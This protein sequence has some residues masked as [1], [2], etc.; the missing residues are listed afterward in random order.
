MTLAKHDSAH[1]P[2]RPIS[3]RREHIDGLFLLFLVPILALAC[4]GGRD[5]GHSQIEAAQLETESDCA[6]ATEQSEV[7]D[8]LNGYDPTDVEPPPPMPSY[9]GTIA[10]K[11][12][13]NNTGAAV[14][15]I[16]I[17]V[18]PG[19]ADM[20]PDLKLSYDSSS[21]SNGIF[22]LGWSI[23]GLSSIARVPSTLRHDGVI[24]P[25]DYDALDRLSLDG[26]RL[27]VVERGYW[28]SYNEYR[29]EIDRLTYVR[30]IN[31]HFVARTKDGLIRRYGFAPSSRS[32]GC[33]K[34]TAIWLMDR[35]EDTV[36][37]FMTFEY[38]GTH[39]SVRRIKYSG[40]IGTGQAPDSEVEFVYEARP[41][42]QVHWRAGMKVEIDKRIKKIIV[43][44]QDEVVRIYAIEY[45]LSPST[46]ESQMV[47]IQEIVPG[48]EYGAKLYAYPK[49]TFSWR[50]NSATAPTGSSVQLASKLGAGQK[51]P[52]RV[53]VQGDFD[54][55]GR[56]DFIV[57]SAEN[58]RNGRTWDTVATKYLSSDDYVGKL[59]PF[60]VE[61]EGAKPCAKRVLASGDFDGDTLGDFVLGCVP[62]E[63][64]SFNKDAPIPT[65]TEVYHANTDGTFDRTPLPFSASLCGKIRGSGDFNGDGSTDILLTSCILFSNPS[66]GRKAPFTMVRRKYLEQRFRRGPEAIDQVQNKY[67]L[68]LLNFFVAEINGDGVADLVFEY[69]QDINL[70]DGWDS[71]NYKVRV[72][73]HV[74]DGTGGFSEAFDSRGFPKGARI[75]TAG[76]FNGDGLTDFYL[77]RQST[78]DPRKFFARNH[79]V[80]GKGQLMLADGLGGFTRVDTNVEENIVS[81]EA[82]APVVIGSGDFNGDGRTD[83]VFSD[84]KLNLDD[85]PAPTV[86]Q[87]QAKIYLAAGAY[88]FK[89]VE[90]NTLG[91]TH[92]VQAFGDF[93]GDGRSQILS[94]RGNHF[95][96]F[97]LSL[98]RASGIGETEVDRITQFTNGLGRLSKLRYRRPTVPATDDDPEVYS[99]GEGAVFPIVDIHPS[100]PVVAQLW[101]DTGL[102]D[103]ASRSMIYTY[104]NAR[105]D[106]LGRGFLGFG[107][108]ESYD[109]AQNLST[110]EL[111]SQEFPHI[112][113][114]RETRTCLHEDPE[115]V[116]TLLT[117][118]VNELAH[119]ST[120]KSDSGYW[121]EWINSDTPGGTGDHETIFHTTVTAPVPAVINCLSREMIECKS[122]SGLTAAETG[123][124]VTC[125]PKEGFLCLNSE[126]PDGRCDHDYEVRYFCGPRAISTFPYIASAEE[127]KWEPS[128][129][130]GCDVSGGGLAHETVKT[131]NDFDEYGNNIRIKTVWD[132]G[133][134]TE[135]SDEVV[136]DYTWPENRSYFQK[137]GRVRQIV[138][139]SKTADGRA[140]S[141]T[142]DFD[143]YLNMLLRTQKAI[144][145]PSSTTH[146]EYDAFGNRT[147]TRKSGEGA[148]T[149]FEQSV[150]DERGRFER[151][152]QNALGHLE[153]HEYDPRF[154]TVTRRVG[155][156]TMAALGWDT[157]GSGCP[158]P[159]EIGPEVVSYRASYDGFG[160][161]TQSV[162]IDGK[163]TTTRIVPFVPTGGDDAVAQGR[164]RIQH[165]TLGEI[166]IEVYDRLGRVLRAGTY[167]PFSVRSAVTNTTYNH[168]GQVVAKSDRYDNN[169]PDKKITWTLMDYDAIGRVT[170]TSY[171]NGL[172]VAT[173][174]DGRVTTIRRWPSENPNNVRQSMT[175]TDARSQVTQ[176]FD[177]MGNGVQ[178]QYGPFGQLETTRPSVG[179]KTDEAYE[180]KAL[181]DAQGNRTALYDP[182]LGD[183]SYVYNGLGQMV[184]QVD[185]NGKIVTLEYDAIG[186]LT[187]QETPEGESRWFFD[188]IDAQNLSSSY[189]GKLVY[190]EY[191]DDTDA[192]A[193][194]YGTLYRYDAV[195]HNTE[196]VRPWSELSTRK[197]LEY[198]SVGRLTKEEYHATFDDDERHLLSLNYS[199]TSGNDIARIEDHEGHLWYDAA[200]TEG[201]DAT[202]AFT[203]LG[204]DAEG[205]PTRYRV[206]Q[207]KDQSAVL[208]VEKQYNQEFTTHIEGRTNKGVLRSTR[209]EYDALG[210]LTGRHRL[211]PSVRNEWFAYDSLNRLT[212]TE[213]LKNSPVPTVM[214]DAHGNITHKAT[215]GD[216]VYGQKDTNGRI[217]FLHAVTSAGGVSY[218]YDD[219]G[220]MLERGDTQILWTAFNKPWWIGGP[221]GHAR[222]AYDANR[223]RVRQES[224]VRQ[225]LSRKNGSERWSFER[226]TKL[227]ID[228]GLEVHL[229]TESGVCQL[230]DNKRYCSVDDKLGDSLAKFY[231]HGPD[232]RLGVFERAMESGAAVR[233][234]FLKDHLGSVTEV[235]GPEGQVIEEM[236]YDAWGERRGTTV[237]EN[238]ESEALGAPAKNWTIYDNSPA[239]AQATVVYDEDKN[240]QVV[241]LS[242]A[243]RANGASLNGPDGGSLA[244]RDRHILRWR[245]KFSEAFGF[246]VRVMTSAGSRFLY[247]SGA[248][249][250][251]EVEVSELYAHHGLGESSMDG[252]WRTYTR[253]LR[254]DLK[255]RFPELEIIELSH[256]LIR[257]SGRI[258]DIEVLVS[259]DRGFTDH[260]MLDLFGL[261]HMNG[262]IYDPRVG[263][264]LSPD[265]FV[266][267]ELDLQNHNR[268]SYVLNRPLSVTDP[269]GY[270]FSAIFSAVIAIAEAVAAIAPIVSVALP[271]LQFA[272]AYAQSGD[273]GLAF[274]VL[275]KG[276]ALSLL[277]VGVTSGIGAYFDG[278]QASGLTVEL[279]RATTHGVWQGAYN[280]I[281]G[282]GGFVAGALAGATAS[283]VGHLGLNR[284]PPNVQQNR[285]TLNVLAGVAGGT[286]SAIGGGRFLNGF[287]AGFAVNKF[288]N[289]GLLKS[290]WQQL[291]ERYDELTDQ[292][293][294]GLIENPFQG[295]SLGVAK[296]TPGFDLDGKG[297]F[298]GEFS[299]SGEV[300]ISVADGLFASAQGG[301]K[302]TFAKL[303][304]LDVGQSITH[305]Q[306]RGF[307]YSPIDVAGSFGFGPVSIS[308]NGGM[309]T[310]GIDLKRFKVNLFFK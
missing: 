27:R 258:D 184:R 17:K 291:Q 193:V 100:T 143:Y 212:S 164:Y 73:A 140:A 270:I 293:A 271:A 114:T 253:D 91:L 138:R 77:G 46:Q 82:F 129:G 115:D 218:R 41:D 175:V 50:N 20:A 280:E 19:T 14:Y 78:S 192:N 285:L 300:G 34:K 196:V 48:T 80:T 106:L 23:E 179:G 51:N 295:A 264:F 124:V 201:E 119:R 54:G 36:G 58:N 275:A 113:F 207:T 200:Y 53:H 188:N 210:N 149:Q 276:A 278:L 130:L 57:A 70:D 139:T 35:V 176:S 109:V 198:D 296:G 2:K 257:G 227:Y 191:V 260:E 61:P 63:S 236:D 242:G 308:K 95:G 216:Y 102:S 197:M 55:D 219:A 310:Y 220:N 79:H 171:A 228:D 157:L 72:I 186:R 246:Y 81:G 62:G 281:S 37:N 76:D 279:A 38:F 128:Q 189:V 288:N 9:P 16:P 99:K 44:T 299:A 131:E 221:S 261:V 120:S 125:D 64:E 49:T 5:P 45:A 215:V 134:A 21:T 165:D 127:K 90:L 96:N 167:K 160:L 302:L 65:N 235:L 233:K 12:A 166:R 237:V 89:P 168:L 268:Y 187:K 230:V 40:H 141:R 304:N 152:R 103:P 43:R 105:A 266:Q 98:L 306:A 177:A 4:G 231:V 32:E 28:Q 7:P 56:T 303:L 203:R 135:Q 240:S 211:A 209:Y 74:G 59:M 118:Q 239:G 22:G 147:L 153:Y 190:E 180:K 229:A 199:L 121:T 263:R 110:S 259:E 33:T 94:A 205:R 1:R 294:D 277:S 250:D 254:Q 289:Q 123:E 252:T 86:V 262:R 11:L 150:F 122:T 107:I 204:Y 30:H 283:L 208:T 185:G 202:Q 15:T 126:Q 67:F 287:S 178:F 75:Q 117:R 194:P 92:T 68:T 238:A 133:Q 173:E 244:I 247:Y 101:E 305:S 243:G 224:E 83:L 137:Y 162:E 286:A 87:G 116:G 232:G 25:V 169:D 182:D 112:G 10:G 29:T 267:T 155:P 8:S 39:R 225:S 13:V 52:H 223:N 256:V 307:E 163:T 172:I 217:R 148:V 174:F 93:N 214:Y 18:A 161:Q 269:S 301:L 159:T 144:D 290:K 292:I 136:S 274:K 104:A 158:S 265:L 297:L 145:A 24:D 170:K 251:A 60:R 108:F 234:Y 111:V 84:A 249:P 298:S 132:A 42:P 69:T 26:R 273:F 88:G 142:T 6:E 272:T 146:H 284:L 156:A 71:K 309:T 282:Q 255:A 97:T 181:Y 226:S 31:G 183:W 151:C 241:E 222:F 3:V 85:G 248:D 206:G 66:R 213:G 47:S 195:G 154:G 245:M